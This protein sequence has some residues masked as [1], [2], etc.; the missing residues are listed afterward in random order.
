[1]YL[2]D[3]PFASTRMVTDQPLAALIARAESGFDSIE[4]HSMSHFPRRFVGDIE[5][6]CG[7][8]WYPE[9]FSPFDGCTKYR[10]WLHQPRREAIEALSGHDCVVTKVQVCLDLLT[11]SRQDAQLLHGI[12]TRHIRTKAKATEPSVQYKNTT[13]FNFDRKHGP[14][15]NLLAYSD[16]QS[17]I[18][19]R[20]SCTHVELR[21][22]GSKHLDAAG[23]RHQD[24]LLNLDHRAFWEENIHLVDIPSAEE[25]GQEWCRHFEKAREGKSRR[26]PY[27]TR[28][29]SIRRMGHSF[30]RMVALHDSGY[31]RA[32]DLEYILRS[33]NVF[34]GKLPS[35]LF[36]RVRVESILPGH[37]N[38]FWRKSLG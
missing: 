35:H 38:G 7:G 21:I 30:E 24:G 25:M 12:M 23:I 36:P 31:F 29:N 37:E 15:K 14:R 8:L 9:K 11:R 20:W 34:G 32:H 1:M 16:R 13:Y 18:A 17:K 6:H 33:Y 4:L 22:V 2:Q 26:F 19:P 27:G 10:M 28:V 3:T 5:Q